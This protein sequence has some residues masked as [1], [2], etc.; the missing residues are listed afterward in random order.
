MQAKI[1]EVDIIKMNNIGHNLLSV[2]KEDEKGEEI[3][4]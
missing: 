1:A 4:D 3:L 2:S